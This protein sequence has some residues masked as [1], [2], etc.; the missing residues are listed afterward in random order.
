MA[1]QRRSSSVV[2]VARP[3]SNGVANI[4][5][6]ASTL[7]RRHRSS[8]EAAILKSEFNTQPVIEADVR[9]EL[10]SATD[11]FIALNQAVSGNEEERK[12]LML[13]AAGRLRTAYAAFLA[14][15][16]KAEHQSPLS[17]REWVN[18]SSKISREYL[19]RMTSYEMEASYDALNIRHQ[20]SLNK[21]VKR[22]GLGRD[23]IWDV[24]WEL[25]LRIV[26]SRDTL[27]ILARFLSDRASEVEKC[28]QS[29]GVGQARDYLYLQKL[30]KEADIFRSQRANAER[31]SR[32]R[33]DTTTFAP[34]D[35]REL[36]AHAGEAIEEKKLSNVDGKEEQ[37]LTQANAQ[38]NLGEVTPIALSGP[39]TATKQSYYSQENSQQKNTITEGLVSGAIAVQECQGQDGVGS[40]TIHN[41]GTPE[42]GRGVQSSV[43]LLDEHSSDF[44]DLGLGAQDDDSTDE[45]FEMPLPTQDLTLLGEPCQNRANSGGITQKDHGITKPDDD[46]SIKPPEQERY[47]SRPFN[48]PADVSEG[49]IWTEA[50]PDWQATF[51]GSDGMLNWHRSLCSPNEIRQLNDREMI[52]DEIV[53][54]ALADLLQGYNETQHFRL[55]TSFF[56]KHISDGNPPWKS[57]KKWQDFELIFIPIH[58]SLHWYLVVIGRTEILQGDDV[59]TQDTNVTN[60]MSGSGNLPWIMVLDS[61]QGRQLQHHKVLQELWKL[62]SDQS[63]KPQD[64]VVPFIEKSPPWTFTQDNGV[65]CGLYLIENMRRCLLYA[66][67]SKQEKSDIVEERFGARDVLKLRHGIRE[68]IFELKQNQDKMESFNTKG[69]YNDCGKDSLLLIEDDDYEIITPSDGENHSKEPTFTQGD[70]TVSSTKPESGKSSIIESG[71]SITLS[72]RD[73][74][75]QF[76]GPF[77]DLLPASESMIAPQRIEKTFWCMAKDGNFTSPKPPS[78]VALL[79]E[80]EGAPA[81]PVLPVIQFDTNEFDNLDGSMIDLL[82]EKHHLELQE[83]QKQMDMFWKV[84]KRRSESIQICIQHQIEAE[85]R[86]NLAAALVKLLEQAF[87]L[88]TD[89]E[90]A[91]QQRWLAQRDTLQQTCQTD[92]LFWDRATDLTRLRDTEVAKLQECFCHLSG[93]RRSAEKMLISWREELT[94]ME[95]LLE[96][97]SIAKA[98]ISRKRKSED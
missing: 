96:K 19:I 5:S 3:R 41:H 45:D 61:L 23:G 77:M 2:S 85:K 10:K 53:N 72:V 94:A 13:A 44:E 26:E 4:T 81:R 52:N 86:C 38:T 14:A 87:L 49:S 90:D 73:C 64:M 40:L 32:Q 24:Y 37:E 59:Q 79:P 30:A 25:G 43:D 74:L 34:S 62:V 69:C 78:L 65:D 98:A 92:I 20:Q 71:H 83:Y 47:D 39:R 17:F 63:S 8:P 88:S 46:S 7:F 93:C 76:Y 54:G 58:E 60:T 36:I 28:N 31:S 68:R 42:K 21:L 56:W 12:K 84:S 16:P 48:I 97:S 82:K 27:D 89:L 51:W 95:C 18:T 29:E 91:A 67:G 70:T 15:A 33:K 1:R 35:F 80:V 57:C 6:T 66:R 55:E 22:L 75:A 11:D 9:T 50:N